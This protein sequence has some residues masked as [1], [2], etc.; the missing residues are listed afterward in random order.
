MPPPFLGVGNEALGGKD[1]SDLRS[2][3]LLAHEHLRPLSQPVVPAEVLG[4]VGEDL[5]EAEPAVREPP[6]DHL[7]EGE[8]LVGE[9]PGHERRASSHEEPATIEGRLDVPIRRRRGDPFLGGCRGELAPCHPVDGVIEQDAGEVDVP[10]GRVDQ[11]V[12]SDPQAVPVA[13]EH[14]HRK[15]R[16]GELEARG[17]GQGAAVGGVE[18]AHV[19]VPH[20]PAAA[21]DPGDEGDAVGVEAQ[22]VECAQEGPKDDAMAAPRAED[23]GHACRAK[24][25]PHVRDHR[26]SPP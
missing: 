4:A 2:A 16:P 12:P 21:A 11:V 10:P 18:G 24:V 17:K 6:G 15:L 1:R 9:P 13:R 23:V 3:A 8:G 14:D 20:E 19:H 26:D 7:L 25:L 5:D 22:A